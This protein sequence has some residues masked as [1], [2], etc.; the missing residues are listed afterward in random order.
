M[1]H[2]A[3]RIKKIALAIKK[4]S[5]HKGIAHIKVPR[6]L[7]AS[8]PMRATRPTCELVVEQYTSR[9]NDSH[10]TPESGSGGRAMLQRKARL[11]LA[12]S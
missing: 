10:L 12:S 5:R 2:V 9:Q 1:Q 8:V 6:C 4:A 11:R 3:A 7:D